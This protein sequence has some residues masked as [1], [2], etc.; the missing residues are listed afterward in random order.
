LTF[1][2]FRLVNHQLCKEEI[3]AT[4]KINFIGLYCFICFTY[5]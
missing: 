4:W 5:F 3:L 1:I 2:L